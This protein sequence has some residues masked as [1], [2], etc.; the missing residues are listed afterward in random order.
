VNSLYQVPAAGGDTVLIRT[1]FPDPGVFDISPDRSKLLVGSCPTIPEECQ[2][3]ALPV[4]GLSPQHI[5]NIRGPVTWSPDGKG[6]IYS[7]GTSL[8]RARADGT[9]LRKITT[10]AAGGT[11][12]YYPGG[13]PRWSPDG[14]RFRFSVSTQTNGTSLWE[15]SSDGGNLHPLLPGWNNPPAECCGSW[16]PDGKYFL[17]QSTREGTT[18]IWAIREEEAFSGRPTITQCN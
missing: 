1:P 10:V 11:A 5:G 18:N 2:I 6:V 7:Q 13:W 14:T 15:V 12:F 17:F 4:L 8:Y 16:T 3:Y 9:E